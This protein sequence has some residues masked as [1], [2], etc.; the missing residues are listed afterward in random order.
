MEN[1]YYDTQKRCQ[2]VYVGDNPPSHLIK[3]DDERVKNF[4]EPT[5]EGYRKAYDGNGLP[6]NELIPPPPE[7]TQEQLN[8]QMKID[9]K[10]ACDA[11]VITI[12]NGKKFNGDKDSIADLKNALDTA[13]EYAEMYPNEAPLNETQWKLFDDTIQT[14]TFAELQEAYVRGNLQYQQTF[15]SF[16]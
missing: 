10:N 4:F 3:D 15:I 16:G 9:R 7:P 13:R 11:L 2:A 12:Q 14:V 8:E 6:F 1:R 5:P